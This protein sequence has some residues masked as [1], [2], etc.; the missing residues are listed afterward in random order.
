MTGTFSAVGFSTTVPIKALNSISV[1]VAPAAGETFDGVVTLLRSRTAGNTWEIV[2]TWDGTSV[3]IDD[4]EAARTVTNDSPNSRAIYMLQCSDAGLADA[5]AY[6][7]TENAGDIVGV[8]LVDDSNGRPI[9]SRRDDGGI[10]FHRA[11]VFEEAVD[12]DGGIADELPDSIE[13]EQVALVSLTKANI[14]D[15]AAGG[16]GHAAGF[17]LVADSAVGAKQICELVSA[18]LVY[19]FGVAGYANGG[20]VTVNETG[21]AAQTGLV[22]AG[23]SFGAGADK[24][25]TF[26]PLAAAAAVRTL[27]KGLSL[28]SSAAFT[29][30]G[31]SAGVA[32]VLVRYRLVNTGL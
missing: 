20:N 1:L 22:S 12:L 5:I 18:V 25:I 29:D 6:S 32:R 30:A 28:V 8:I 19:D 3:A 13:P 17:V 31:T 4:S 7:I 21:G 23:N 27:A 15:T 14:I 2:E 9:M 11:V 16:F 10:V 26:V 24:S